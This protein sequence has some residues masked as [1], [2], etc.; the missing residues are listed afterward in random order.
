MAGGRLLQR[1]CVGIL[2][3]FWERLSRGATS[4]ASLRITVVRRGSR[5]AWSGRRA[6]TELGVIVPAMGPR[7]SDAAA[8]SGVLPFCCRRRRPDVAARTPE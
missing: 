8:L 1:R 4:A 5:T 7:R 6:R 2:L 3:A